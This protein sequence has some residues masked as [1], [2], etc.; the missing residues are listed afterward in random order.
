MFGQ[1]EKFQIGAIFSIIIGCILFFIVNVLGD[2]K[3]EEI[4]YDLPNIN[5]SQV[6]SV[7]IL[8]I[9]FSLLNFYVVFGSTDYSSINNKLN[10]NFK[11]MLNATSIP[12]IITAQF[13]GWFYQTL[14]AY[15]LSILLEVDI[16][17]KTLFKITGIGYIGF[18]IAAFLILLLNTFII[19]IPSD[20]E[21]ATNAL[22]KSTTT[23]FISKA[24]DFL[25]SII[26][27]FCILIKT[28]TSYI[29]AILISFLPAVLLLSILQLLHK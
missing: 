27:T 11:S 17:L 25:T 10:F 23:I 13:G 6:W 2:N 18:V 14:S 28:K 22:A 12:L 7:Q 19:S 1:I 26:I 24:G 3:K 9:I 21:E 20:F 4:K 15:T 29:K 16:S 5:K 8:L